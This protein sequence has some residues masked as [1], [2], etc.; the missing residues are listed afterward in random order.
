[1]KALYL[2]VDG[3]IQC[4]SS[5]STM[6]LLGGLFGNLLG[7]LG[8]SGDEEWVSCKKWIRC[9][10]VDE[11]SFEEHDV[12]LKKSAPAPRFAPAQDGNGPPVP[13]P[14]EEEEPAFAPAGWWIHAGFPNGTRYHLANP[15]DGVALSKSQIDGDVSEAVLR[16]ATEIALK[17]SSIPGAEAQRTQEHFSGLAQQQASEKE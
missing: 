13:L 11:I 7:S 8:S 4:T 10:R 15:D 9:S 12:K 2:E 16:L 3:Y 1:M 5:S 17:P 6:G 14:V